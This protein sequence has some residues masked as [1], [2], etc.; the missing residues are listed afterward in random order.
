MSAE[1]EIPRFTS[2][3]SCESVEPH[4]FISVMCFRGLP[5][6]RDAVVTGALTQFAPVVVMIFPRPWTV[7][8][9]LPQKEVGDFNRL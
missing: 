4:R 6:K 1:S 3:E 9:R 7:V 5:L 2:N 8:E